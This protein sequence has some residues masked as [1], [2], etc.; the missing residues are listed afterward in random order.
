[1]SA[2]IVDATLLAAR[3]ATVDR[4]VRL[5][6]LPRLAEFAVDD[7]A[8]AHLKTQFHFADKRVAI[9]GKA[10]A[11][12]QLK[13]QRCLGP[14]IVPVNDDFHVVLIRSEE[15]MDQLPEQQ[16]AV[17]AE[18]ARL[19]VVW[20]LE[21]QLL[22]AMPLVPTHSSADQCLDADSVV[23]HEKEANVSESSAES[24]IDTQR[25]FASLRELLK[26]NGNKAND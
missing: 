12:L 26:T 6:D 25:P 1:V 14:V 17:V 3:G 5:A 8:V 9:A 15:E 16:D 13:C 24:A 23:E 19:N 21:E 4:D 20:L 10:Q 22:L 11:E 2:D 18:A 7:R